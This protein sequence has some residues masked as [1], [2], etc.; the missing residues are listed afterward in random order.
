M[1][2]RHHEQRREGLETF[3]ILEFYFLTGEEGMWVVE[4]RNQ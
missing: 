3:L 4:S 2:S 1:K